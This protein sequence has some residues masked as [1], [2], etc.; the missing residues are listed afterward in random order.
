MSM[1]REPEP[2]PRRGSPYRIRFWQPTAL[3]LLLLVSAIVNIAG[4][5][6]VS[7]IVGVVDVVL[8][9]IVI[10]LEGRIRCLEQRAWR[11]GRRW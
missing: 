7:I 4:S 5:T 6:V 10:R 8:I 11:D 1:T 2:A 3:V 9:W